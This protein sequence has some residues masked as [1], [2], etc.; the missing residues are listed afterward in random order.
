MYICNGHFLAPN[1]VVIKDNKPCERL[2]AVDTDLLVA[3][4]LVGYDP[5]DGSDLIDLVKV[6]NI[7][8]IKKNMPPGLID[9]IPEGFE[10]VDP[11]NGEKE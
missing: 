2:M 4:R 7:F 6:D 11:K 8:F 9:L 3:V 5:E 1:M 10:V